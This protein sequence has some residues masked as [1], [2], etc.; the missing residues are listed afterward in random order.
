MSSLYYRITALVYFICWISLSVAAVMGVMANDVAKYDKTA[1]YVRGGFEITTCA[2]AILT[3]A[4][5]SL[6]I[7]QQVSYFKKHRVF[8]HRFYCIHCYHTSLN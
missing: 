4:A 8:K 3:L 5:E 7:Y 1:D 6:Q 2:Y